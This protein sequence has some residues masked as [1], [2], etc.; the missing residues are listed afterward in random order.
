M[1]IA[2]MFKCERSRITVAR[3]RS[4]FRV[5]A[6]FVTREVSIKKLSPSDAAYVRR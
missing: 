1:S 3:K 2:V 5:F 4:V 6:G